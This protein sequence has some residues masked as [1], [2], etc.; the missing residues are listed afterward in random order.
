MS[1]LRPCGEGA[2]FV[3]AY[4]SGDKVYIGRENEPVLVDTASST[5]WRADQY[6]LHYAT[7]TDPIGD[8]CWLI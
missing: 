6:S 3:S 2:L 5:G 7:S 8:Q 1:P 4:L